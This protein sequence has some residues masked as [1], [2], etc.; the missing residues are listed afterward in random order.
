MKKILIAASIAAVAVSAIC[1]K[2]SADPVLMTVNGKPVHKSEFEY[3]YH[4]NNTQQMQPQTVDQYLQMFIDYKLKVADAEA[5]G[6]D[7]TKQF[8]DEFNNYRAELAAPYMVDSAVYRS[9][10][11]EAYQHQ[12]AE[13]KVAHIM[14]NYAPSSEMEALTARI[15][16]IRTSLVGAP[17]S[18]WARAAAEYSI[19]RGTKNNAGEMG[20]LRV[21]AYPWA[22]E[23]AA[24]DTPVGQISPIVDSSFGLHLVKVLDRRPSRGEVKASHILKLT[25]RKSPEEAA[26]AKQQIDSIYK[27]VTAPGADFAAIAKAE[28]EDPGSAS[29]GGELDWFGSGVMVAPFDSAAFALA[30]GQISEPVQTAYG[31][32]IIKNTGHRPVKSFEE[33]RPQIENTINNSDRANQPR[34][35]YLK[36]ILTRFNGHLL[37]KGLDAVQQLIAA[38]A[39]GYDS[40]AIAKLNASNIAVYEIDGIKYPVSG[41]M[42]N[43]SK[44]A[45]TDPAN[46]RRLIAS[47]AKTCLD[48][49]AYDLERDRLMETNPDYRNLINEYRDGILLFEISNNKVWDAATKDAAGLEQ[50]FRDNRSN[51]KWDKPKYKGFI[52][53][54]TTDSVMN[55]AKNYAESLGDKFDKATFAQDMAK[56][57]KNEVKV[58]RIIAAQGDN[59]ISDYL[60]FDGPAPD[61]SKLTWKHFFGFGGHLAQQPEEA[62]DVRGLVTTDYQNSLE[63]KWLQQLR[64]KYKVKVNDKVARTLK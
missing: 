3:L 12:T 15:D 25:A 35:V 30:E 38:N 48:H 43:V 62:I 9:L 7:T 4:K 10:L 1:A 16:S 55:L 14:F 22:F 21:S 53:F 57:F 28:S 24:Y 58:E 51:Y 47:A 13:V 18:A 26:R 29:R 6:L 31:Y 61:T 8:R 33:A 44:T 34:E 2:K 52:V 39:G 37:D 19:D 41:V 42:G 5:A 46:A 54:A 49:R 20:W 45:A 40:V 11:Q 60:F 36:G 17:D 64:K 23:K 32:H 27:V 63:R 59:P 56:K 50:Y